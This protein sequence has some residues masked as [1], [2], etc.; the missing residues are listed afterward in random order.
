MKIEKLHYVVLL[1]LP[2]LAVGCKEN[3]SKSETAETVS[4]VVDQQSTVALISAEAMLQLLESNP[5]VQLLDVRTVEEVAEGKIAGSINISSADPNFEQKVRG[6]D[7]SKPLYIY[8]RSGGRSAKSAELVKY[9]GFPEIYD[10]EG[11][12][13]AWKDAGYTVVQE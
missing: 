3:N 8:C 1:L 9:Y 6:L 13:T 12:I 5:D 2:L 11:G 4:I 7:L 10:L